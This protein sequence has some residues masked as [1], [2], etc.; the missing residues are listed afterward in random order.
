MRRRVFTT[1]IIAAS[2]VGVAR[3]VETVETPGNVDAVTVYRGQALVTRI[4]E[5]TG[6]AGLHEIVVTDLPE[7]AVPG[8]IHAESADGVEVRSVRYRVRPV[9]RD[10][11]EEVRSLDEQIRAADDSLEANRRRQR[12]AAE[13]GAYLAKLEQ[14]VAPTANAELTRGV[15]NSE[16]LKELTLFLHDERK[17]LADGE[18]TLSLEQRDLSEQLELLRR[19]RQEITGTSSRTAREAIIFVNVQDSDRATL[20]LRYLVDQATWAPSYNVRAETGR[21]QVLVEYNASI[22]Q[23]SGEDWTDVAMTLS[24]ATP[25]LV[26]KAPVLAPLR[27]ALAR[28]QMEEHGQQQRSGVVDYEATRRRLKKRKTEAD[29]TRAQYHPA[30]SA[31]QQL[32]EGPQQE[33][34]ISYGYGADL[35]SDADFGSDRALNT[36][37]NE[38]QNLELTAREKIQR[39]P[40]PPP[41]PDEGV[42]VT[43]RVTSRTSLPSRS[44]RQLIRIAPLPMAGRF[45]K[46]ATP[47]LT[48][49]VYEEAAVTNESE[50]VLLAGPV[51]TYL[52]GQFVGHGLIPTVAVGE[53]FTVGFGIDSS[54][55]AARELIEKKES[56]QGGNR[57]VDFTYRLSLENFGVAPASVRVLDRLPQAEGSDIKLTLGEAS[58][59]LSSDAAYQHGERKQGILR[60]EVDVPAGATGHEAAAVEYSF[61]LEYDRQM[62]ISGF[63]ATG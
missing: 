4:V 49:F 54:L 50:M 44:D 55:R 61:R 19:Q 26:A 63:L 10:V 11:R 39:K 29:R 8:S 46:V 53:S 56:T 42:T 32:A 48:S 41:G 28:P 35:A 36:L 34:T 38:L 5:L 18:L 52:A 43:Y 40:G 60:W 13:H 15:L 12:L 17:A 20:R 16:T 2:V 57:V 30:I 33:Q 9:R 58:S 6:P 21:S 62:T 1:L 31:V 14:F 24:T 45:Y 23:Q 25:S 3:A 51:A 22:Q 37:A 59:E 47:V 27:I 7:H